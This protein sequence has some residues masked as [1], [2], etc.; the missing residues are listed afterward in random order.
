MH[1][2]LF[3][4]GHDALFG[5]GGYTLYQ[6]VTLT[7]SMV[8]WTYLYI[9]VAYRGIKTKF[10]QMPLILACGNIVWEFL[11][12]FVFRSQYETGVI[13]GM[14]SAFLIDVT[15]FY[16]IMRYGG[17]YIHQAFY[18]KNRFWLAALGIAL[19]TVVWWSFKAQGLDSDG[20]GTS[21]NILN[22]LIA[23]FWVNQVLLIKDINLMSS[24]MGW[25]KLVADIFVALFMMSVFPEKYFSYLITWIAVLFDGIYLWVYYQRKK[26]KLA[27]NMT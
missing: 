7:L 6:I 14:G 2:H 4:H 25:V 19:W 13:I 24:R 12:A 16:G 27:L 11:W 22:A 3:S 5:D 26:G 17:K 1:S 15:I 8:I 23:I 9:Y 18:G 20:G 10:V 21:G